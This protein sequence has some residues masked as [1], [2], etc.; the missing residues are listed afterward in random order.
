MSPLRI[1]TGDRLLQASMFVKYNFTAYGNENL[2]PNSVKAMPPLLFYVGDM[3]TDMPNAVPDFLD[4]RDDEVPVD[5]AGEA[6]DGYL[7]SYF[8]RSEL[9][10]DDL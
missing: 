2:L 6:I 5:V 10:P 3:D 4:L 8:N 9:Q 1:N 7:S